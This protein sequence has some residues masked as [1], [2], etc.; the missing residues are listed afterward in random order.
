M[1][2]PSLLSLIILL[3]YSNL[4]GQWT[5]SNGP[6]GGNTF[7][8][9]SVNSS[10][11]VSTENG[12]VYKSGDNGDTW[13]REV[14]GLP[15]MPR[16]EELKEVSGT[17]YAAIYQNGIYISE[18]EAVSWTALNTG[19]ENITFRS[20]II[21]G[22]NIY[23]SN[24]NGGVYFSSDDGESWSEKSSG[25]STIDFN[26]FTVFKSEV[27]GG[28]ASVY[29]TSDQGDTWEEV[30]IT[31]LDANGASA[32]TS[33]AST[34]YLG[35]F[36]GGIFTS[37]NGT[38]WTKSTLD[39]SGTITSMGVSGDSVYL[40]TGSGKIYFSNDNG[41]N[42]ELTQNTS[43][44]GFVR[45]L[46]VQEDQ[47]IM[48]S[49]DGVFISDD[50]GTNWTESNSGILALKIESVASTDNNLFAGTETQG[51][52]RSDL[53]GNW[54]KINNG[55]T[56]SNATTVYD[57]I[58]LDDQIFIGT[59]GGVYL[60]DNSGDNW[61]LKYDPGL[62]K[63]VQALDYGAGY[64]AAGVNGSGVYTSS[65]GGDAWDL[66][67]T[68][69]LNT[70]TSYTS[71]DVVGDSIVVSTG[72][73]E[74]F[75]S[76]D[77]GATWSD[78][79]IPGDFFYSYKVQFVG[80]TLFTG[81]AKG[82]LFSDDLGKNWEFIADE[83][84]DITGFEVVGDKIYASSSDGIFI[85]SISRDTW[86]E[87]SDGLISES[88]NEILLSDDKAYVGTDS[89]SLWERS[90]NEFN[91]QPLVLGTSETI[92]SAEDTPITLSLSDLQVDDD[93]DFPG[94]FTLTILE[95]SNYEINVDQSILPDLNFNG[96]L[97]VKVIVNDGFEN[98][99]E[100]E[101]N[102][103]ITPVNDAPVITDQATVLS[104]PMEIEIILELT[105]LSVEDVDNSYPDD[106]TIQVSEGNNYTV[107]N[108]T[109]TPS[110]EFIGTL[111][112][113]VVVNDGELDS[114]EFIISIDV[115]EP[116]EINEAFIKDN[117]S[118]YPNPVA[119]YLVVDS[120]HTIGSFSVDIYS[121]DGRLIYS[122]KET[123]TQQQ[124][125]NLSNI[126]KGTYIMKVSNA[127]NFGTMRLIKE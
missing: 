17:L 123:S 104:T 47:I 16:I 39:V 96:T 84:L 43:T 116:L 27:Y 8:I 71:I 4:Y 38:D 109:I 78:I 7:E 57:I 48:S 81:T 24:A 105:Y 61:T 50:D 107:V 56:A 88:V 44:E 21:D 23:G 114:E 31:G 19:I 115:T 126:S 120:N 90:I 77:M 40:T 86:T 20:F 34:I 33:T 64:F 74:I 58:L 2:L 79:S 15:N 121:T 3:M 125:I 68:T 37:S 36:S 32:M 9:V 5:S 75:L 46:L 62:N 55:L 101:L 76:E 11:F 25:I 52:F 99:P 91:L 1:K 95:G 42:W 85:T 12:G 102:I 124:K 122:S 30:T 110:D 67:S 49:D 63:A 28:G 92:T 89:T 22:S 83:D 29:K 14:S 111:S 117:F 70:E 72:D 108:N 98:S 113:P 6:S 41:V 59:G 73:G 94:D 35:G 60:S 18:D 65:N 69:D 93:N 53:S 127:D 13:S 119:N 51:I 118:I 103:E 82:F 87:V 10:L 66:A 97:T 45:D 112:V 80:E 54:T 100:A 26:D 106:F